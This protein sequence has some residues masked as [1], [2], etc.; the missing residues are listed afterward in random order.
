MRAVWEAFFSIAKTLDL[1]PKARQARSK[2]QISR[3]ML[4]GSALAFLP[5]HLARLENQPHGGSGA[6]A[7][8]PFDPRERL[9]RPV[10]R[11]SNADSWRRPKWHKNRSGLT[12]RQP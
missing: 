3:G 10:G 12:V 8:S 9:K 2:P 1:L 11:L 5:I 7:E 6:R 4:A